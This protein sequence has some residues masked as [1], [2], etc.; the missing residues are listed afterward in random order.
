MAANTADAA[1]PILSLSCSFASRE[2]VETSEPDDL[3]PDRTLGV[4]RGLAVAILLQ[5]LAGFVG[6]AGWQLFR[7]LR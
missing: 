3:L 2:A 6:Y 7:H 4:F 5:F 1:T